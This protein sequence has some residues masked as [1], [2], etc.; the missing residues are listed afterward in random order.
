[1]GVSNGVVYL[2]GILDSELQVL[3]LM[4]RAIVVFWVGV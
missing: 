3:S 1:M 4:M 2:V